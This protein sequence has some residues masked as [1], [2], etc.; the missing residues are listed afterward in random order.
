TG[1]SLWTVLWLAALL[2][3]VIGGVALSPFWEP[4]FAPIL[5]WG[6]QPTAQSQ[7]Y[8]QLATRLAGIEKRLAAPAI[9]VDAITSAGNALTRRVDRLEAALK[10]DRQT[11]APAGPTKAELQQLDQRLGATEAQSAAQA[12]NVTAEIKK[13]QPELARLRTVATELADRLPV[14][15]RQG[16]ALGSADRTDA[17]WLLAL[18]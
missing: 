1:G 7:E 10:A 8:T 11:E 16:R 14:L 18:L 13:I 12:A 9:D 6:E 3:L 2:A 17:A 4:A 15:E 5:P